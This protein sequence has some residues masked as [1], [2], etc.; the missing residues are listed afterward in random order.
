MPGDVARAA[1]LRAVENWNRGDLNAYME[2][3]DENIVLHRVP[4]DL[5]GKGAVQTSYEGMW[6][7][8]PGSRITLEDAITEGDKVACRYT[9]DATRADGRGISMFGVTILHFSKEKCVERWD[10]E[11]GH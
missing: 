10:L 11:A 1:L 4:H 8:F 6:R 7:M 9:V 3:Y 5:T 2:L